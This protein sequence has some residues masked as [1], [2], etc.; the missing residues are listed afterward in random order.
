MQRKVDSGEVIDESDI[1]FLQDVLNDAGDLSR[2]A[3]R[4]PRV[5][6]LVTKVAQLYNDIARK[7]WEN[8][9]GGH[10]RQAPR[11]KRR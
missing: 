9:K 7:A 6:S 3:E 1:R 10:V 8:E 5:Q 11:H 4:D 2:L